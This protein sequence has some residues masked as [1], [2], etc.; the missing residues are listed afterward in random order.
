[1]APPLYFNYYLSK[2]LCLINASYKRYYDNI[3]LF[4]SKDILIDKSSHCTYNHY[5]IF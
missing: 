3:L 2:I 5:D 1:M 4:E